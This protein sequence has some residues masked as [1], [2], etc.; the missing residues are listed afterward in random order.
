MKQRGNNF[1][2]KKELLFYVI[3]IDILDIALII[4]SKLYLDFLRFSREFIVFFIWFFILS[5][6]LNRRVISGQEERLCIIYL[7][8]PISLSRTLKVL[9]LT[10]SQY[11]LRHIFAFFF[12]IWTL[13]NSV[14]T[15]N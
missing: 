3:I 7:N 15:P 6:I 5:D 10:V 4:V 1:Y 13:L 14:Q 2:K 8:I 11:Y 9:M 12:Y